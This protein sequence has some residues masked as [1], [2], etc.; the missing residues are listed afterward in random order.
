[1]S[2]LQNVT[3]SLSFNALLGKRNM[4]S[5]VALTGKHVVVVGHPLEPLL[6]KVAL[7]NEAW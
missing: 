6:D 7:L 4:G 5:G 3:S 1:V 2:S